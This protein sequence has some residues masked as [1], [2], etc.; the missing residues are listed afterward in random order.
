M[1]NFSYKISLSVSSKGFARASYTIA[2]LS[3]VCYS[4]ECLDRSMWIYVQCGNNAAVLEY[5]ASSYL[6]EMKIVIPV[7]VPKMTLR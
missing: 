2:V 7:H 6:Q 4:P 1:R 3:G 5:S